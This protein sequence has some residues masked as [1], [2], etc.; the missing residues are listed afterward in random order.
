MTKWLIEP[1]FF[2]NRAVDPSMTASAEQVAAVSDSGAE[3]AGKTLVIPVAG[4][5]FEGGTL[6]GG[7]RDA[8]QAADNSPEVDDI[9]LRI[10]SPGGAVDGLFET[11][12]TIRNARKPVKAVVSQALSAA[13]GLASAAGDVVATGRGATVGSVGIVA[14]VPLPHGYVDVTS[15]DAP[16]KRPDPTTAEGVAAIRETIDPI[17]ALFAED[18]AKGRGVSV[19]TVNKKFG[20]GGVLVAREAIARGMIDGILG[21][22]TRK[23]TPR[24]WPRASLRKKIGSWPMSRLRTRPAPRGRKSP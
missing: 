18:I 8:I 2:D 6:Y 22:N 12:D 13:Y 5:L 21:Q 1:T 15:T 17:H 19:E 20:R 11:I 16:N 9:E 3:V 4:I 7:I 14:S 10:S 24:P 23:R